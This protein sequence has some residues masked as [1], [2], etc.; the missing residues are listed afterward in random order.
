MTI[1]LKKLDRLTMHPV[2]GLII[3]IL[4]MWFVFFCTFHIGSYPQGWIESLMGK[5]IE[6]TDAVMKENW[7]SDL[8]QNGV[9]MGIGSVLAFIPNI[10]ILF[11]F[12]SLMTETGYLPRAALLMDKYMHRIGLHGSSFVPL[13]MGF[14]CNVPAIMA[15]RSI[16]NRTDRLLTIMMIPYIPCSARIPTF[17]LMIGIFFPENKTAAMMLLYFGAIAIAVLMALLMKKTLFNKSN[18]DIHSEPPA[19]KKPSLKRAFTAMFDAAWQYMKKIGTVVLLAVIIVWYLDNYP[20]QKG[21]V[22]EDSYLESF[23]KF[24]EPAMEPLGFDWKMSVSLI[25]GITAKEF[26]VSTLGVVYQSEDG[27]E[28][29]LAARIA[30]DVHKS[31]PQSGEKTFNKANALSF[32]IFA[33]LYMPCVGTAFTIRKESGS[34]KW[35]IASIIMT[36]SVAWIL[37]FAA[38]NIGSS[39][40]LG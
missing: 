17:I 14:G 32:M 33:L 23:G 18:D 4:V 8:L 19:Y 5:A 28:T 16:R 40:W 37:S 20:R 26:I 11:F 1:D 27:E 29:S 13:L 30:Q 36:L 2:Y 25:T 12:I 3:F 22:H 6:A 38:Y 35:M 34:C 9:I 10:L 21:P 15:T 7:L 39:I 24:V 31:G